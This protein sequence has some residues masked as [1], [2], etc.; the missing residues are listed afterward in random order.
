MVEICIRLSSKIQH[1][2]AIAEDKGK[3]YISK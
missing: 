1:I 3:E 2:K